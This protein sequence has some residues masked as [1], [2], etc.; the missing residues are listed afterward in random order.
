MRQGFSDWLSS[1]PKQVNDALR[2]ATDWLGDGQAP[3]QK[4]PRGGRKQAPVFH[5]VAKSAAPESLEAVLRDSTQRSAALRDVLTRTFGDRVPA[6]FSMESLMPLAASPKSFNLLTELFSLLSRKGCP[7]S[8]EL[9]A[10]WGAMASSNRLLSSLEQ[11]IDL[12]APKGDEDWGRLYALLHASWGRPSFERIFQLADGLAPLQRSLSLESLERLSQSLPDAHSCDCFLQAIRAFRAS[13]K[14]SWDELDAVVVKFARDE[15]SAATIGEIGELL[16]HRGREGYRSADLDF[17][18]GELATRT[19][20]KRYLQAFKILDEHQIRFDEF[21]AF[22]TSFA[23]HSEDIEWLNEAVQGLQEAGRVVTRLT[24]VQLREWATTTA[25]LKRY[26]R[27]VRAFV[28]SGLMG[29]QVDQFLLPHMESEANAAVA[30]MIGEL[31]SRVFEGRLTLEKAQTLMEA[32][33][34]R[35][36]VKRYEQAVQLMREAGMRQADVEVMAPEF[37]KTADDAIWLEAFVRNSAELSRAVERLELFH[38]RER[39]PEVTH[40]YRYF[41]L[42]KHFDE[43]TQISQAEFE[44]IAF[45]AVLDEE[46]SLAYLME[47]LAD[48]GRQSEC[49]VADVRRLMEAF[50]GRAGVQRYKTAIQNFQGSWI[51]LDYMAI[52]LAT[53]DQRA[54]IMAMV[55]KSLGARQLNDVDRNPALAQMIEQVIAKTEP[56]SGFD[57]PRA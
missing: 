38:I 22:V 23:R 50:P 18:F 51:G 34:E 32:L 17:L 3:E 16:T 56:G 19:A 11:L 26:V 46:Q 40:I 30:S 10:G 35:A 41:R 27:G 5:E 2:S 31:G 4:P 28:D 44:D 1:V 36:A 25:A 20:V 7:C 13:D 53:T 29:E 47:T 45:A 14:L 33:P 15:E 48:W 55:G 52:S 21:D 6:D 42:R 54:S 37:A 9:L 24:L 39:C 57:E 8:S 12:V 49:T 43:F